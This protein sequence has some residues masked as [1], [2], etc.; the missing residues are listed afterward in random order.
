MSPA[1]AA[2]ERAPWRTRRFPPAAHLVDS[3]AAPTG[4]GARPEQI[5][6]E[7]A[8]LPGG[9]GGMFGW[10]QRAGAGGRDGGGGKGGMA[11]TTRYDW[12]QA[13]RDV[14]LLVALRE[15]RQRVLDRLADCATYRAAFERLDCCRRAR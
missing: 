9:P 4:E 12:A 11:E 3:A 15:A 2:L 7:R 8:S 14:A 13:G 1:I 6:S 10:L 5:L